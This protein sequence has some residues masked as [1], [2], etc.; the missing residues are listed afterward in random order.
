L[1]SCE[2]GQKHRVSR[3]QAGQEIKCACGKILSVPTLRGLSELPLAEIEPQSSLEAT[4]RGAPAVASGGWQG[5]R[6]VT[7]ALAMAGCLIASSYCGWFSLQR[8]MIDTSYTAEQN[9]EEGEQAFDTMDPY[10]LTSTWY[11]F[12]QMGLRNKQY[13]NFYWVRI[14]AEQRVQF[15]QIA[16]SIALGF[17][18]V[19][20][21]LWW[22]TKNSKAS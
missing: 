18:A 12:G 22:T 14:F 19:G 7:M 8:W 2:C 20:L 5:W 1:L 13:P 9:I 10:A 21:V 6:G 4:S 17:A 15:A 16:G 3:S 11:N